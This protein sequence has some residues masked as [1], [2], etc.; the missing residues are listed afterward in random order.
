VLLAIFIS[1]PV[2]VI[3]QGRGLTIVAAV[4][5]GEH[6]DRHEDAEI[7][8][9]RIQDMMKREKVKGF[10]EVIIGRNVGDAIGY[11]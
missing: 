5:E 9:L 11:L 2:F 4:L 10:T 7:A 1:L 6:R 8:R 3:F